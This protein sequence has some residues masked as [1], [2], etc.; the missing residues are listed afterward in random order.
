MKTY[1]KEYIKYLARNENLTLI[2][3]HP[4]IRLY[5]QNKFKYCF[6]KQLSN[7]RY[8]LENTPLYEELMIL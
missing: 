2:D 5:D 1:S 6:K 4:F 8:T 3:M 7:E